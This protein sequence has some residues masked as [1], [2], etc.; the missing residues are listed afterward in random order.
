M[1]N[2]HLKVGTHY[3]MDRRGDYLQ[4]LSAYLLTSIIPVMAQKSQHI[5]TQ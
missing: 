4:P 2:N 1:R 3:N 5:T